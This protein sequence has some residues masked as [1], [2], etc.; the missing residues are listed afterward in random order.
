[1][2]HD[3]PLTIDELKDLGFIVKTKKVKGEEVF[4]QCWVGLQYDFHTEDMVGIFYNPPSFKDIIEQ[5]I[6]Y[7]E[8]S[9]TSRIKEKISNNV[10]NSLNI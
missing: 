6:T 5:V 4:D 1:M 3:Q 10:I 2:K 7:T 8:I 9:T